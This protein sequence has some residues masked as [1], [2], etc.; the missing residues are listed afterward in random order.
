VRIATDHSSFQ[1]KK[2]AFASYPYGKTTRRPVGGSGSDTRRTFR[3][4]TVSTARLSSFVSV[5]TSRME[6]KDPLVA[7]CGE[8]LVNIP[9]LL[10]PPE[11]ST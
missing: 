4:I 3:F 8:R 1:A 11:S 6:W 2:E 7:V 10:P 5:D 9:P